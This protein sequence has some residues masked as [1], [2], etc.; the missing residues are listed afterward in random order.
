M[1]FPSWSS[2]QIHSPRG[3]HTAGASESG[4]PH[5]GQS[6][7]VAQTGGE[8]SVDANTPEASGSMAESGAACGMTRRS[9]NALGLRSHHEAIHGFAIGTVAFPRVQL[10][11]HEQEHCT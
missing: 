10:D 2:W 8:Q 9:P 11:N 7:G 4:L 3:L 6:G 5:F 1:R